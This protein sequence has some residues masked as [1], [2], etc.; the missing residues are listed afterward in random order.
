MP[1]FFSDNVFVEITFEQLT[2]FFIF[3]FVIFIGFA[4]KEGA[5]NYEKDKGKTKK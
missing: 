5:K 2:L 3:C 4:F 1:N